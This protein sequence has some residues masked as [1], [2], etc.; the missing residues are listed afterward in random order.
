VI[1]H[2]EKTMAAAVAGK[3]K[4]GKRLAAAQVVDPGQLDQIRVRRD[5]VP[6]LILQSLAS[7]SSRANRDGPG[8]R[9]GA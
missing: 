5:S 4:R 6:E 7:P 8:L 2:A 1:G 9:I 3:D